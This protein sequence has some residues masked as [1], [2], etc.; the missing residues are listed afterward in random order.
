MINE[1]AI[2]IAVTLVY[3]VAVV[4]WGG[5]LCRLFPVTGTFWQDLAARVVS[6]CVVM[7]AFFVSLAYWGHLHRTEVI[8]V[9]AFGILLSSAEIPRLNLGAGAA[10]STLKTWSRTDRLLGLAIVM[11]VCRSHA[12]GSDA[13]NVE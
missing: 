10:F 9:G 5:L 6:G 11:F 3:F 2:T 7:Y 13:V 12:R 4:G 8:V 1:Y